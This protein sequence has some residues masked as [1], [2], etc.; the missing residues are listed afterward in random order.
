[1]RSSR[2]RARLAATSPFGLV[3]YSAC[4]LE[5]TVPRNIAETLVAV[6]VVAWLLTVVVALIDPTRAGPAGDL[7]PIIGTIA[8]GAIAAL[9]IARKRNGNGAK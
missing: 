3:V 9:T 5:G 1:M 7:A 6:I 8:G 4:E 2:F